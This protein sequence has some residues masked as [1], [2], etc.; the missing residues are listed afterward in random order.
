MENAIELV[1][2]Y[3]DANN[4]YYSEDNNG[5]H[6]SLLFGEM[7]DPDS[8]IVQLFFD[9][10]FVQLGIYN[11]CKA[12]GESI[13]L[14]FEACSDMNRKYRFVKFYVSPGN[15]NIVASIDAI[16]QPDSCGEQVYA[17]MM[18]LISHASEARQSIVERM[19]NA[20]GT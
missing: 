20:G 6:L 19:N 9:E 2:A 10:L 13:D 1:K 3:F 17:L 8:V 12:T 5:G 4:L 7:K 16:C 15:L 14:A 18:T 11:L